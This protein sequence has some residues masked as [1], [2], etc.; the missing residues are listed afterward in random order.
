MKIVT[1]A[2]AAERLG[3]D[4]RYET[5]VLASG[6]VEA[7]MLEGDLVVV[8]SGDP[9]LVAADGMADR[10]FADWAE[11]LKRHGIRTIAGRVV[12]DDNAFEEETLGFGWSWDD[13]PDDYAAGVG[14]LQF[15]ENAVRVT[16]AP[17]PAA[18]DSAGISVTPAGSGLAIVNAVVTG[19]AGERG[20]R[21]RA[22]AAGQLTA[23]AARLDP[24]RRRSVYAGGLGRQPDAVL[25]RRAAQRADRQ[26]HRRPRPGRRYRRRRGTRRGRRALLSVSY[27]S[28]P[29]STLAVRLMKASQNQY[30]ET[31]LKTVSDGVGVRSAGGRPGR[32]AGHPP[33][34][35]RSGGRADSARRLRALALRLRHA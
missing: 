4:Y 10:V 22:P 12:G 19:A 31:L 9:S 7:G 6:P 21:Q 17:G 5:T 11:Q 13:L 28:A 29:L 27:R 24:G 30:A 34:V 3:W 33:E 8:G 35:G 2:A 14:A 20:V 26:R 16:V 23:G 1:L 15:N 32:G 18:G 25:R